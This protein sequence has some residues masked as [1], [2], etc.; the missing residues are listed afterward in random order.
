MNTQ[1][2]THL[3]MYSAQDI[4]SADSDMLMGAFEDYDGIL[5]PDKYAMPSSE[6]VRLLDDTQVHDILEYLA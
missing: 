1:Q 6:L 2:R 3:A 5:M 4:I